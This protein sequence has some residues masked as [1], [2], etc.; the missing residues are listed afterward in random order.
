LGRDPLGLLIEGRIIVEVKA[1]TGNLPEVFKY[2]VLSYLKAS[3]LHVGLLINFGNKS[4]YIK[5]FVI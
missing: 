2:Q 4:C 1:V 5:R 3:G